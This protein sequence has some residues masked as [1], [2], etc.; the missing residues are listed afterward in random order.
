LAHFRKAVAIDP[1]AAEARRDLGHALAETGNLQEASVEL[2]RAT[3]LS[4]GKD[5]LSLY[6][7]SRVYA[8]LRR[9]AEAERAANQ[10]LAVA[11]AE[12]NQ[13]LVQVIL[14]K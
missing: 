10:A 5:A 8:D 6:F 4:E 12:G 2:E 1:N 13:R 14:A 11:R 7:L 9:V 3:A